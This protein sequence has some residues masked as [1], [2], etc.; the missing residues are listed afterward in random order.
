MKNWIDSATW[1]PVPGSLTSGKEY[2]SNMHR[3][4]DPNDAWTR[5]LLFGSIGAKNAGQSEEKAAKRQALSDIENQHQPATSR[6]ASDTFSN[7][8][9]KL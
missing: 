3:F 1:K 9:S 2:M 4:Q 5:L 8:G 7:R 6:P